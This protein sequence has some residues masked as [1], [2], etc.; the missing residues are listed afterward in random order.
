MT[1]VT[2]SDLKDI[3]DLIVS[4]N[5]KIEKLTENVNLLV[6]GQ[7]EIKGRINTLEE[8]INGKINTLTETVKSIDKRLE[9]TETNEG[10]LLKDVADLKGAKSLIIPIIVAVT[11]SL[12][13]LLIRAIPNP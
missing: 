8:N 5:N 4:Q 6:N 3:K 11:T 10:T 13:T 2:D 9:K 1:T 12:L 7:T